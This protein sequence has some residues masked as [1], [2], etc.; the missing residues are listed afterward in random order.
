LENVKDPFKVLK[1]TWEAWRIIGKTKPNVI[2]SMGGF[3]SV[4]VV[5]AA[6]LRRVPSLIHE[7]DMTPGLANK[8]S[9]TFANK[10]LATFQ[11][12]TKHLTEK[13]AVYEGAVV[14]AA[15]FNGDNERGIKMIEYQNKYE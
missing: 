10:V 14:R 11:D 1:G 6:K 9:I 2:F 4:P 13:K 12:K 7:S 3:V 8:L 5:A 15:L